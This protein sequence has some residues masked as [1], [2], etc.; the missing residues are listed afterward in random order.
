MEVV[1][2]VEELKELSVGN[3]EVRRHEGTLYPSAVGYER[4]FIL[5]SGK[6]RFIKGQSFLDAEEGSIV[7]VVAG[8]LMG[9]FP[10]GEAT[11][12]EISVSGEKAEPSE[13]IDLRSMEPAKRHTLVME[14]F[15]ELKEAE[16]IEIVNDHDP[17]PL[18]FQ[19]NLY[20]PK[21]V[22]WEYLSGEGDHWRVRIE[23]LGE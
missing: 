18:Y 19:M 7:P 16:A 10:E 22:G 8:E 1:M 14:K 20:F 2:K 3:L 6:G 13:V 12:V 15:R 4:L 9:F 11:L 21:K 23:R 17:L 5:F